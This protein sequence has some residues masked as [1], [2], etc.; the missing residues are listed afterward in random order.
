MKREEKMSMNLN[1]ESITA[2]VNE[3]IGNKAKLENIGKCAR[4]MAVIDATARIYETL[5]EII[6]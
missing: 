4:D 5:C 3:L 6:K 1:A 2:K